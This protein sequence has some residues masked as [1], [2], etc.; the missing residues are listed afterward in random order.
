MSNKQK[1]DPPHVVGGGEH[2]VYDVPVP[3]QVKEGEGFHSG[4]PVPKA[5]PHRD[6]DK[7]S[8]SNAEVSD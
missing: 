6:L 5:T 1:K 2:G 4:R 7:A 3:I 8:K